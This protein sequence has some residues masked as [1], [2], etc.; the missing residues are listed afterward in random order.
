MKVINSSKIS[1]EFTP[2]TD[3]VDGKSKYR[4]TKLQLYEELGGAVPKGVMGLEHDGTDEALKLITEEDTGI[5]KLQDEKEDGNQYEIPIFITK[6]SYLFNIA[7]LEFVC[8]KDKTFFTT[9][10]SANYPS[11]KEA[12]QTLYPGKQD[13]RI[14]PSADVDGIPESQN[15]ETAYEFLTKLCY[16]YKAKSVF[17]FG[18]E[19]LL[20]K[21]LQGDF[22]SRGN[23]EPKLELTGGKLLHATQPYQLN[24]NK[25][26]NHDPYDPWKGTQQDDMFPTTKT[27]YTEVMPKNVGVMMDYEQYRIVGKNYLGHIQNLQTNR[28]LMDSNLYLDFEI[29]STDMPSYKLGDVLIYKNKDE[30]NLNPFKTFLVKSNELFWTSDDSDGE[31]DWTGLRLSWTT[32]LVGLDKGTWTEDEGKKE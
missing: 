11:I 29:R 16:S 31:V 26:L 23:K 14:E 12:I 27:D 32:K 2:W 21:D 22:D 4:I 5:I 8:I 3:T 7:H 28:K 24:Y 1:L 20:I 25:L 13:I 30:Y 18:W 17:A 15:G 9:P 19:G 10:V 6:R